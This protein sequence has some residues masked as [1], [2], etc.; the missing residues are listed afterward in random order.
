AAFRGRGAA[1]RI[2]AG[3][4]SCRPLPSRVRAASHRGRGRRASPRIPEED[5]MIAQLAEHRAIALLRT[6]TAQPEFT[7]RAARA[8][9]KGGVR[10][11]EIT[12]TCPGAIQVI[13]QLNEAA[14]QYMAGAGTVTT[15][16]EL[17]AVVDAGAKFVV[18]PV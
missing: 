16:A 3:A 15:T 8:I 5:R 10:F 11:I 6:R 7:L 1:R 12:L 9:G 14:G 13:S 18:T 17:D 4:S 2:G